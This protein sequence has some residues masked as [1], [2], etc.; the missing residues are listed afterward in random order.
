MN[1]HFFIRFHTQFGQRL[2]ISGN[3]EALGND[4]VLKA[5]PMEYMNDEYWTATIEIDAKTLEAPL[6][7][8][9]IFYNADQEEVI[10]WGD[11]R[12]LSCDKMNVK[13]C[14][15]I[16]T[17]NH[18]GDFENVF[19]TQPFRNVLL[20][21]HKQTKPKSYKSAS[22]VFKVKAPLLQ[23]HEVVCLLGNCNVMGMWNSDAPVLMQME[24]N[25]WTA[26]LNLQQENLPVAYKY[27]VYNTHEKKFVC[28]ENG[29]NRILYNGNEKKKITILHDGFAQ[30]PNHTWHGAGVAIP[31]FSLRSEKSGGVGEFTDLKL[32]VQWAQRVGL[33]LI[34]ILPVNDTTATHRWNDS[35]PYAAISAFALHP[36]Y[37]NLEKIAGSGNHPVIRSIR[38]KQQ[39]LNQLAEVDYELVMKYKWTALRELYADQKL[40]FLNDDG[41]H[42]FFESNRH[43]LVPYAA[44]CYLRDKYHSP[45]TGKWKTHGVFSEKE[46]EKLTDANRKHYD[47]IAIHYFVQYHLHLQ[48]QEAAAC[49]HKHGIILKGDIPI[50]IYRHSCDAWVAPSLYKMDMQ[51]GA[52]PDDFAVKGQNWGFPTY[53]W[54]NMEADGFSWW[55]KRFEH[56]SNYFDAFR[57]DHILGF[58]RIWSIPMHAVEGILGHFVPAIPVHI[59]EFSRAGMWFDYDRLCKPYINDDILAGLM[60]SD[61][62][63][64]HPFLEATG[65]GHYA[66]RSAFDTQRK[67]ADYFDALPESD[68]NERLRHALYD[69][70][71]NVILLEAETQQS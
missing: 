60:G 23:Q 62:H 65:N 42:S 14:T 30:L 21:R 8:K 48:L 36:L 43:W 38:K 10:E 58:F 57:I 59:T 34:Q 69:L 67:V 6:R 24:G 4:D 55:R 70:I 25:W 9:Y 18:A 12:E 54:A 40:V 51:A 68:S 5:M 39:Q 26:K 41:F 2:A 17:W 7:Y 61:A 52:P 31:V 37:V 13:E 1:I 35:Y 71:S 49:A 50:G 28:Y 29:N 44:F 64:L 47:E 3:C 63:L 66:L 19:Y 46:I 27:G 56:M 22:H 16:D 11:D 20:P 32:L 45:D 33:K 15:L 53:H